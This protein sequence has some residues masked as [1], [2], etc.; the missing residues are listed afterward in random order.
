MAQIAKNTV[1]TGL[2]YVSECPD[3]D[4]ALRSHPPY[5]PHDVVVHVGETKL[6][7]QYIV[8]FEV[9]NYSLPTSCITSVHVEGDTIAIQ[10][11]A[12]GHEEKSLTLRCKGASQGMRLHEAI[13][14]AP[15]LH[16]ALS[17]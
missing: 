5:I 14:Y 16:H 13:N 9:A 12:I 4:E 7:L 6:L 2:K 15:A 17:D 8:G 1:F 3:F 10:H 11:S